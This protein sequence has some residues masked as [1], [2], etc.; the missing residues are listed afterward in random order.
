[1]RGVGDM[2]GP[3]CCG[4]MVFAFMYTGVVVTPESAWMGWNGGWDRESG[5]EWASLVAGAGWLSGRLCLVAYNPNQKR[6]TW[7][8]VSRV[9]VVLRSRAVALIKAKSWAI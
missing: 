7:Q 2:T 1:M 6:E 8:R 3:P 4:D 9:S 5:A